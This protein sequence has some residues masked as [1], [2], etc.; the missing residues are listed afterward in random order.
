MNLANGNHHVLFDLPNCGLPNGIS[1]FNDGSG[2]VKG[3]AG[4]PG[5]GFLMS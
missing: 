4:N 2:N 5:N 1:I 3:A